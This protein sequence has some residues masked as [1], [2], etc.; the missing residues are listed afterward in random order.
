[1]EFLSETVSWWHWIVLGITLIAAEIVI[2]SFIIIWFGI[3]A[4]IV[5]GLDYLFHTTFTNELFLWAGLSAILLGGWLRFFKKD[6]IVS[7]VGQSEGEY[8]D[9]PGI[10]TEELGDGRFRARFELPVLG[11]RVWI[12]E[13]Q[14]AETLAAGDHVKVSRVYGQII[15]VIKVK[16]K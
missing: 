14:N 5:G 7:S 15:K 9:T 6:E 11:D 16:G 3:A 1:M 13:T 2:P 4:L 10:I 8:K 12:V